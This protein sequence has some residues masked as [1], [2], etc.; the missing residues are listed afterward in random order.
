MTQTPRNQEQLEQLL[1]DVPLFQVIGDTPNEEKQF[2]DL[3][4]QDIEKL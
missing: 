2:T 3:Y 4:L 1:A